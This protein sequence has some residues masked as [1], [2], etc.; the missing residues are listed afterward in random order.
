[1]GPGEQLKALI[2]SDFMIQLDEEEFDNLRFQFG[3]SSRWS[4]RRYLPLTKSTKYS[5]LNHQDNLLFAPRRISLWASGGVIY[6][7]KGGNAS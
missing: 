3:A 1:M 7:I 2:P 4:G 5:I 6:F